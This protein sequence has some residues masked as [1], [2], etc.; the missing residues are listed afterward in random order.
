MKKVKLSRPGGLDMTNSYCIVT[1]MSS[2]V[3]SNVPWLGGLNYDI[4][5]TET[6]INYR[7]MVLK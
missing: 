2:I 1:V 6:L 3:V 7:G 4:N 5:L